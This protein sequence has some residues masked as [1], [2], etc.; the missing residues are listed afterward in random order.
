MAAETETTLEYIL[1]SRVGA[2]A[3]LAAAVSD[4]LADRP[5]QA[6]QVNL[7]LDELLT[8]TITHGL[9]GSPAHTIRLTLRRRGDWLDLS[10]DDDAPPF[11]PFAQV[12]EPDLAADIDERAIGGLGVHFVRELMDEY[13]VSHEGGGN[14]VK[15]RKF[16]GSTAAED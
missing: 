11:D 10:I 12:A 7:C 16:L 9:Q 4:L 1:P 15:L 13:L 8:N 2:I 3:D 14:H 5:R 6:F